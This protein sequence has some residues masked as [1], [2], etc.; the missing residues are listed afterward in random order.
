MNNAPDRQ[1][2]YRLRLKRS[3]RW[4]AGVALLVVA[5]ALALSHAAEHLG[6]FT[7][8]SPHLDD[9]LLG[10]PIAAVFALAGAVLIGR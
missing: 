6:A 4:K 1:T 8:V 9:L 5:P 3:R 10:W 2:P 7:V